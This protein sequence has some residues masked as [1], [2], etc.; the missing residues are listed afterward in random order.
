MPDTATPEQLKTE[1]N[2]KSD[3]PKGKQPPRMYRVLHLDAGE[4]GQERLWIDHD[5]H[6]GSSQEMAV[7]RARQA[8]PELRTALANGR[9]VVAVPESYFDALTLTVET[10]E[11]ESFRKVKV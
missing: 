9:P 1:T 7:K 5:Y 10:V 8:I 3:E 2:G 11:V 4:D 6:P